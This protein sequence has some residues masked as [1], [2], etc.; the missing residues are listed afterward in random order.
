MTELPYRQEHVADEIADAEELTNEE[1]G[2]LVRL[3]RQMW[4][5]GGYLPLKDLARF[6]RAG[7]RWG[8]IAPAVLG[9]LTIVGDQASSESVLIMLESSRQRRAQAVEK[10]RAG[11]LKSGQVRRTETPN[12]VKSER[13]RSD[14]NSLMLLNRNEAAASSSLSPASSNQNQISK[15]LLY[16]EGSR[17]LVERV[18]M[19]SLAARSQISKWLVAVGDE[20]NLEIILDAA[21]NENLRGSNLVVVID[22][23]VAI[24]KRERERGGALPLGPSVISKAP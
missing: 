14:D 18:G 9:K 17:L 10:G 21:R 6:A 13:A 20:G 11:G 12:R 3:E 23:R 22:Q 8:R 16:E 24:C 4:R 15:N 5:R 2:A 7:R 1:M 19:R